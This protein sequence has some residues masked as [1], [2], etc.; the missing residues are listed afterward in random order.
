[1]TPVLMDVDL[2]GGE[3]EFCQPLHRLRQG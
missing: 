3:L 1:V 2:D